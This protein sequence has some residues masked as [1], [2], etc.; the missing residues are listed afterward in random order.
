MVDHTAAHAPAPLG[1][2]LVTPFTLL[3]AALS[4]AAGVVALIRFVFGLG[5]VTNLS[6]GYPW[7]I[8]IVYDVVIGSALACGG[9]A[10]ALLVYIFNKGEYH[11][12]VRPALLAS[13][14]GYT[15]AGV[16]VMMD[17]GRYWNSWHIFWPAYAQVNSVLFEVATCITLYIFVMWIEFSP[18]FLDKIGLGGVKKIVTKLM[19]L[20]IGLGVLLPSM[21]QSSLG[22]MLVLFGSQ[23][24]PLWQSGFM[25]P[26]EYLLTAILMGFAA[27]VFEATL[28]SVGFK[29]PME[30][31]LLAKL[32]KF[33][34]GLLLVYLVVRI[35]GLVM[36]GA[37]GHAFRFSLEAFWFW[38]EMISFIVPLTML[39]KPASRGN[40][41]KLF[42][43]AVLLM[44]GG[45]LLRVNGFLI[46]FDKGEGW[47][48]FPSLPELTITVGLIAFEILAYTVLVKIL[49]VLPTLKPADKPC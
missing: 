10:M 37:I 4:L 9:Y 47:H 41:G 11:P 35:G 1:G 8:W 15:L 23:I 29:R 28:V 33:L 36:R 34:W 27:V 46:G 48:Y 13:L 32:A 22:T 43:A 6:D 26:V 44:L 39:A 42:G 31:C 19:F 20:F 14:L 12:L 25:M 3:L 16:S 24:D 45:F 7:G 30:T 21:H 18:V 2:K 38:A 49:P 17:M 40:P 5:A